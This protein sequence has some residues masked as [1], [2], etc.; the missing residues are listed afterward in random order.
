MI[1]NF[2]SDYAHRLNENLYVCYVPDEATL[3]RDYI[4][5]FG[6]PST[7]F[8]DV[9]EQ[10]STRKC[11]VMIPVFMILDYYLKGIDITIPDDDDI[12]E[13]HKN[14]TGY[15]N[16]WREHL[17]TDINI[18]VTEYADLLRGLEELN[19]ALY[20]MLDYSEYKETLPKQEEFY[21][22]SLLSR[23]ENKREEMPSYKDKYD[24][25]VSVLRDRERYEN[26]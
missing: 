9:D 21:I 23:V 22:P 13:I 12:I 2:R 3:D 4:E 17:E 25:I 19:M 5:T 20:G 11:K 26:S 10:L 14:I 6:V 24:T 8:E 1:S 7:G 15:L 18:R 16:E